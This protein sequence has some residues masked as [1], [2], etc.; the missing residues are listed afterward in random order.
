MC[1]LTVAHPC[2]RCASPDRQPALTLKL[3]LLMA[4]YQQLILPASSFPLLPTVA[5]KW[6]MERYQPLLTEMTRVLN[7]P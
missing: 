6:R 7:K 2:T 3:G 4:G 5:V 1:A